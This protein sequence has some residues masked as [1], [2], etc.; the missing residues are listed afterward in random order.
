MEEGEERAVVT[1]EGKSDAKVKE[2]VKLLIDWINDVLAKERIVVKDIQED[3][4]DGLV[5]QKLLETL[6]GIK[7][8][9][10]VLARFGRQLVYFLVSDG[11]F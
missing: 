8:T 11:S 3:L 4:Y 2:V 7:V 1:E 5:I 9:S 10:A 6:A